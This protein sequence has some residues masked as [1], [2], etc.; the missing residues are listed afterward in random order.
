M[1][2]ATAAPRFDPARRRAVTF[3]LILV[4]ALASFE[5]TVVSTAMP[6]IIGDLNGL[7]LYS[8]VFSVYLLAS[9]VTMPLYGRLADIHGR[10]RILLLAIAL[11]LAGAGACAASRSMVQLIVARGL[12]GLGAGGLLPVALV[13]SADLYSLEERARIQSVFS[14]VWGVASLV[15]PL[16]GATLTMTF[17][18]RSI[19]SINL[20]LGVV[21]FFLVFTKMI[22]SR[23]ALADPVDVAGALMLGGAVT[24]ILVSVLTRAG[25][26]RLG[27]ATRLALFLGALVLLGAF[28][29]LQARRAHPLVPPILFT[30]A[31][32]AA[33]YVAGALLGTT[34]YGID[35]FV[36][37]F[38]QG[39]R[40]GTA[41]AAG[42]VVT[43]LVFSWAISAAIAAR[44]I[45]DFGFR[46]TALAGALLI[47]TGFCGLIAAA[48]S[49]A[50][51][52]WISAAC[53]VVGLGL[54]PSS[55][56]QVLAIQDAA[57]E[58]V[59]GV[60]TSLVPFFRTIGGS[61]GVGALGGILAAG[62]S[63]RLG[64][65]AETAGAILAGRH[66]GVSAAGV[67]P[68]DLRHA[69]EASLLPVFV[70]LLVL[71]AANVYVTTRFPKRP[72]ERTLATSPE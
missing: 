28:I 15:G 33:P 20:P 17:G 22:E 65:A 35:T 29:R 56:S 9:T 52:G 24:G 32:T 31:A 25:S 71:A 43:P 10:R 36:P 47:V 58:R 57:E 1:P 61:L 26:A 5:A 62:L 37:L 60:A 27:A 6:T 53:A 8:W 38:V 72:A 48:V 41:G 16:L 30:K 69:I 12:Q 45:V 49:D 7:T 40:G 63:R 39:A 44:T 50:G 11:F 21:A 13:V 68:E 67:R 66:E 23:G 18:W 42:A 14:G 59:R 19:F 34:I 46:K 54:G 64:D 3:A 2:D 70:V 55:M 4:T 51:V